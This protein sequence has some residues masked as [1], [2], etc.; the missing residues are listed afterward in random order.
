VEETLDYVLREMTSPEGGFYSTQDADSEGVEGKFYAW[1]TPELREVLGEDDA[2]FAGYY[3]GCEEQGNW[4]DPA[5]HGPKNANVLFVARTFGQMAKAFNTTPELARER[6]EAA[7]RKLFEVRCK[8]VRPHLDDKIL[9]AWNGQMIAALARAAQALDEPQYLAAAERAAGFLLAKLYDP[10]T[11][12]LLRR[13]RDGEAKVDGFLD[14]YAFFIAGLMEL[15]EASLDPKWIEHA[16]G[17]ADTMIARFYDEA[18]SGFWFTAPGQSD[19]IAR[20][21]DDYDGAEPSGNSIAIASLQQIAQ[22]TGNRRYQEIAD[23]SL[24]LFAPH[25]RRQPFAVPQMLCAADAALAKHRQ[26]VI[27]GSPDAP[28]TQAMLRAVRERYLPNTIFIL[29]DGGPRQVALAK[30]LEFLASIKP[31]NGKATAYV[32]ENYA[33]QAPTNDIGRLKELLG[34]RSPLR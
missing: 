3:F 23:K 24:R 33:C 21:K 30:R 34:A 10:Q 19:I 22:L 1:T 9:T 26:I 4:D 29:A 11:K 6:I 25:L 27:A 13:W 28:D 2:K 20:M 18:N 7:K 14:D 5:G 17:L 31:L 15:Y 8:R 12:T 16:I 32:C